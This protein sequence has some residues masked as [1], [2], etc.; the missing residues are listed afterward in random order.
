MFLSSFSQ[1]LNSFIA[2]S[3][4][5]PQELR[6]E[7]TSPSLHINHAA[8]V[9]ARTPLVINQAMGHRVVALAEEAVH[10]LK[11]H[12]DRITGRSL[13]RAA[14]GLIGEPVTGV[15]LNQEKDVAG[16]NLDDSDFAD[17][18]HNADG[19]VRKVKEAIHTNEHENVVAYLK[20]FHR[21]LGN[22]TGSGSLTPRPRDYAAAMSRFNEGSLSSPSQQRGSTH[23]ERLEHA[24]S[25]THLRP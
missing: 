7:M 19:L 16:E 17:M 24:H 23:M 9:A 13:V 14:M 5:F 21:L 11:E 10:I 3:I 2:R 15:D 25:H 22:G 8:S 4:A 1:N 12:R 18:C 6:C 20:S